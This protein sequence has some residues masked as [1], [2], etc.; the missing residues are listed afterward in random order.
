[1]ILACTVA[2]IS[3]LPLSN[4][5][6]FAEKT[7]PREVILQ[8]QELYSKYKQMG[9]KDFRVKYSY[10][11]FLEDCIKLYKDPNWTFK[12]K[13]TIDKNLEQAN[14]A[15]STDAIVNT[16]ILGKTK[17][18][19]DKYFVKFQACSESNANSKARFL[20]ETHMEKFVGVGAKDIFAFKCNTYSAHI[21]T[22]S[23]DNISIKFVNDEKLSSSLK[24]KPLQ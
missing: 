12:G 3:Q 15:N 7:L 14:S 4:Q 21:Q 11:R 20:V 23:P 8:C 10:K 6:V 19:S 17:I 16:K 5:V 9:E 24:T 13:N 1:M 22:K 2:L 18:A